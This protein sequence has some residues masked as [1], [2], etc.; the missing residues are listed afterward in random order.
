MINSLTSVDQLNDIHD[1]KLKRYKFSQKEIFSNADYAFLI[2]EDTKITDAI[3]NSKEK[4]GDIANCVTGF[5]SS[6]DKIFL[7][8]NS[9]SLKNGKNYNL[10]DAESIN[11]D[12][13]NISCILDGIDGD[14]HFIPIVKGGNIK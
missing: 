3:R 9:I 12:Y 8:V 1:K 6:N 13:E 2:S 7:Q 11:R 10:V 4:I 5:Y 14:E